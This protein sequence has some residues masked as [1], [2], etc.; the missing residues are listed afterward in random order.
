MFPL[1]RRRLPARAT[2]KWLGPL[3]P[4]VPSNLDVEGYNPLNNTPHERVASPLLAAAAARSFL[5]R[6]KEPPHLVEG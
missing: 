3:G 6:A 2:R 1:I 4:H 5:A